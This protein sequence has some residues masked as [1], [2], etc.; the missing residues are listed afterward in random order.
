MEHDCFGYAPR[1][2][3][4]RLVLGGTITAR[5]GQTL[6]AATFEIEHLPLARSTSNGYQAEVVMPA[7]EHA[8]IEAIAGLVGRLKTKPQVIEYARAFKAPQAPSAV[9]VTPSPVITAPPIY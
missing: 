4:V 5:G 2:L 3:L 8:L 1:D 9:P 6:G 7:L